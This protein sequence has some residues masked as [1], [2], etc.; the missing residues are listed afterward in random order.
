MSALLTVSTRDRCIECRPLRTGTG[1]NDSFNTIEVES[2]EERHGNS[3]DVRIVENPMYSRFVQVITEP[4][5]EVSNIDHKRTLDWS[6]ANPLS[7]WVEHLQASGHVLP[8]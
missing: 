2:E 7:L 5:H 4:H 8:E 6:C 3:L 1:G